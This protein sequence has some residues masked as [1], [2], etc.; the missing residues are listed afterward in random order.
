[1]SGACPDAVPLR[2]PGGFTSETLAPIH[3]N[4]VTRERRRNN[5]KIAET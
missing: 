3:G 4:I 2:S 1:M 5:M